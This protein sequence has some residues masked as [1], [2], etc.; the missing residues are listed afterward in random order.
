M[1]SSSAVADDLEHY[2]NLSG[3]DSFEY[4]G[5]EWPLLP[6]AAD[7]LNT[8]TNKGW[9]SPEKERKFLLR[10]R[11][12]LDFVQQNQQ[13]M[14]EQTEDREEDSPPVM[15][16]A[17]YNNV[18]GGAPRRHHRVLFTP[19]YEGVEEGRSWV[20]IAK[21]S[22]ALAAIDS[23]E[24][25]DEVE[26]GASRR[27]ATPFGARVEMTRKKHFGPAKNPDCLCEHCR[28]WLADR[29]GAQLQTMRGRAASMGEEQMVAKRSSFWLMRQ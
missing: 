7:P 9:R 20:T 10:Q 4:A 11:K 3:G 13:Q 23:A 15:P 5:Q 12:M 8:A 26:Q 28:R 19:N 16:N 24:M 22:P 6:S 14:R 29:A 21:R 18:S 2:G 17:I 25:G 27:R 1:A